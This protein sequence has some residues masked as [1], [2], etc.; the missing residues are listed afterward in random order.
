MEF[1]DVTGVAPEESQTDLAL[2]T[3][4]KHIDVGNLE[5]GP[6]IMKISQLLANEW[7]YKRKNSSV[8]EYVERRMNELTAWLEKLD[9]EPGE[10]Q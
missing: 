10:P 2:Q 8:P 7:L 1:P 9:I 6:P 3:L 4:P 5:W